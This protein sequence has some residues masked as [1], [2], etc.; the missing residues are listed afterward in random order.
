MTKLGL[1]LSKTNRTFERSKKDCIENILRTKNQSTFHQA[2]TTPNFYGTQQPSGPQDSEVKEC[3][4]SYGEYL[5]TMP[6]EIRKLFHKSVNMKNIFK[7][8]DK[9]YFCLEEIKER[10]KCYKIDL[11]IIMESNVVNLKKIIDRMLLNASRIIND[12]KESNNDVFN[13][14]MQKIK[15][16]IDER[17]HFEL[18]SKQTDQLLQM[19]KCERDYMEHS[20]KSLQNELDFMRE[21]HRNLVTKISTEKIFESEVDEAIGG[22]K[23]MMQKL[24]DNM[25]GISEDF[26]GMIG[27]W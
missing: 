26:T 6:S 20:L 17:N 10:V 5:N 27:K 23:R 8:F 2:T 19:F 11:G 12:H 14:N 4:P 9:A 7:D 1:N 16:V 22:K 25:K 13:K 18:K 21:K 3:C 24:Y 15:N